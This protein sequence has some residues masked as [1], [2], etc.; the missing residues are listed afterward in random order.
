LQD[1]IK[2][3]VLAKLLKLFIKSVAY[4]F[5][6]GMPPVEVWLMLLL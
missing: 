4:G 5:I 3:E 1:H 6:D 2:T